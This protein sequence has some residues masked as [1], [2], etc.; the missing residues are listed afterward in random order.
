M[1]S[2]RPDRYAR[3]GPKID[4]SD[5]AIG[6]ATA[7]GRDVAEIEFSTALPK[8]DLGTAEALADDGF[9]LLTVGVWGPRLRSRHAG[10]GHPL[11]RSAQ[12]R[13]RPRLND[14]PPLEEWSVNSLEFAEFDPKDSAACSPPRSR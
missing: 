3:R 13:C 14:R 9:S 10:G 4:P 11:A 2:T 1:I 12:R 6:A 5:P 8:L 7:V